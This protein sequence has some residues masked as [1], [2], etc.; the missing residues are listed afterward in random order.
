MHKNKKNN[1]IH[2]GSTIFRES[3]SG[4]GKGKEEKQDVKKTNREN[5]LKQQKWNK[6]SKLNKNS[7]KK[8]PMWNMNSKTMWS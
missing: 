7:N 3:E 4:D 2:K 1:K 5:C 6:W 8:N